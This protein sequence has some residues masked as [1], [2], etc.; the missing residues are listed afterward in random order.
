MALSFSLVAVPLA[1][2][3]PTALYDDFKGGQEMSANR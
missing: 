2:I 1:G 3:E